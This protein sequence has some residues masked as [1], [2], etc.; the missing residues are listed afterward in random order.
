MA[1]KYSTCKS[2]TFTSDHDIVIK[3]GDNKVSTIISE[4][5]PRETI[6]NLILSKLNDSIIESIKSGNMII[7]ELIFNQPSE[8]YANLMVA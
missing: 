2:I 5:L 6:G 4:V 3:I 1:N 7:E 8:E